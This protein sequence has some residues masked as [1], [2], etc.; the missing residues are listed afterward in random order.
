MLLEARYLSS[1]LFLKSGSLKARSK[2][3]FICL[4]K[5][6]TH[7]HHLLRFLQILRIHCMS[8]FVILLYKQLFLTNSFEA[9]FVLAFTLYFF[10]MNFHLWKSFFFLKVN[11]SFISIF[12]L[13]LC[14][15]D[16]CE[17][18]VKPVKKFLSCLCF[19]AANNLTHNTWFLS[20]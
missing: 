20:V 14:I 10:A 7:F 17:P 1:L 3:I 11:N 13:F 6:Q 16:P 15:F 18:H 2:A 9:F 12:P 19:Y 4:M 5:L 8:N